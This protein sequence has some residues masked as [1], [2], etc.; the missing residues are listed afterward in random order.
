MS[1][2]LDDLS[3]RA[4]RGLLSRARLKRFEASLAASSETQLLHRQDWRSDAETSVLPGDEKIVQRIVKRTLGV[5]RGRTRWSR[6]ARG[7]IGAAI[8][9]AATVVTAA[10]SR[11]LARPNVAIAPSPAV[12]SF[13]PAPAD[14][15]RATAP[16]PAP[17]EQVGSAPVEALASP[18]APTSSRAAHKPTA[19]SRPTPPDSSRSAPAQVEPPGSGSM[20]AAELFAGAA[21]ARANGD[22]TKAIELYAALES[23]FPSTPEARD[24]HV[25]MAMLY[26]RNGAHAAALEHDRSYLSASP[27]GAL[28]SDALWGA[29]QALSKLGRIGEAR[30]HGR[31]WCVG[32]PIQPTPTLLERRLKTCSTS[33]EPP[34]RTRFRF[35]ARRHVAI[36]RGLRARRGRRGPGRRRRS[37]RRARSRRR[38]GRRITSWFDPEQ[39][40]V[41]IDRAAVVDAKRV[42]SPDRENAI[43]AWVTLETGQ[44]ARLYFVT[45]RGQEAAYLLRDL[46]L[47][48]GVDELGAERI[49]QVVSSSIQVLAAGRGQTRREDSR[50]KPVDDAAADPM[51]PAAAEASPTSV[52]AVD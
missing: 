13:R 25:A 33:L 45:V 48:N 22:F 39:F 24:S 50:A 23:Q 31:P 38:S 35:R 34:I 7:S 49:A 26:L 3:V 29:A 5:R 32:S 1:N 43:Y 37:R 4:R 51:A 11:W 17:A 19:R 27:D 2:D 8:L 52:E 36:G 15:A 28:A 40:R 10:T 30:Q 9:F 42:L 46:V 6:A 18:L 21:R 16:E 41:T 47:E 44:L 12:E 14:E 20:T